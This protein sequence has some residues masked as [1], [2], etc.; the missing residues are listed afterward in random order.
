MEVITFNGKCALSVRNEDF[1][2][3]DKLSDLYI[4]LR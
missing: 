4:Y 2:H 1:L 3:F